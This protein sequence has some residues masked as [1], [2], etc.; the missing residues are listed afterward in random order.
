MKT[1]EYT[2]MN[3]F[4]KELVDNQKENVEEVNYDEIYN[5]IDSLLDE[6]LNDNDEVGDRV[7]ELIEKLK[8]TPTPSKNMEN[9]KMDIVPIKLL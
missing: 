8:P 9:I 4:F 6:W 3:N 7:F 2:N 5:E 1:M